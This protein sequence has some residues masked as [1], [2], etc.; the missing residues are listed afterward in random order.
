MS[1]ELR[2]AYANVPI[3]TKDNYGIWALKVRAY[4]APNDHVR[5]IQRTLLD[6]G[7]YTDPTPPEDPDD[8]K[9]WIKSERVALGLI[10]GTASDLHFELCHARERGPAWEY[11]GVPC[12]T[13]RD[14]AV[15]CLDDPFQNTQNP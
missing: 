5:V 3:L 15:R 2:S 14:S 8:L 4:L 6:D 12:P 9:D 10:I 1:D 7:S 11:R 13:G